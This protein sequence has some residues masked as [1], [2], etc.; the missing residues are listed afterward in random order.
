MMCS[1]QTKMIWDVLIIMNTKS[2]Q[3]LKIQHTGSSFPSQKH[4]ET[5]QQKNSR[6]VKTDLIQPSRS[7]YNSPLFMVPKK[8]GILHLVQDFRKLNANSQEDRYSMKD[9]NEC[10]G[11]I[12]RSGSTIF[13]TLDLTSECP[14]MNSQDI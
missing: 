4:T 9:T 6:M 10:I 3:K 5:C 14:W 11:N 8:D 7:R 1:V 2:K 12:G 13:T